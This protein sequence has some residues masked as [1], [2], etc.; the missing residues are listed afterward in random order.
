[1]QEHP[2]FAPTGAE[3]ALALV[4]TV[5]TH[6]R[7]DLTQA[8]I[9]DTPGS[10]HDY[11]LQRYDY[12]HIRPSPVILHWGFTNDCTDDDDRRSTGHVYVCLHRQDEVV[13]VLFRYDGTGSGTWRFEILTDDLNP[14]LLRDLKIAKIERYPT[15]AEALEYVRRFTTFFGCL[16]NLP[17]DS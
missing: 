9:R 16:T 2:S 6:D 7:L 3:R 17:S 8:I 4:Q 12:L 10:F 11:E 1:M 13:T 14:R 5:L 15:E